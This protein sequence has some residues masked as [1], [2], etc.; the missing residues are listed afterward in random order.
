MA[1]YEAVAKI[2][3][4]FAELAMTLDMLKRLTSQGPSLQHTL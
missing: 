4:G 3:E 1:P 2:A